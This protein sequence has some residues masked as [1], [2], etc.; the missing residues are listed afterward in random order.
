MPSYKYQFIVILLLSTLLACQPPAT[1]VSPTVIEHNTNIDYKYR[2][3]IVND[4]SELRIYVYRG[5]ALA[6]LGHNHVI[7]SNTFSGQIYQHENLSASRFY[8]SIPVNALVIDDPTLRQ[9]AGEQFQSEPSDK[10]IAGTRK[11]ML[12]S[13]V[14]NAEQY[15]NIR[16]ALLSMNTVASENNIFTVNADLQ[17]QLAGHS[18]TLTAPGKILFRD[19]KIIIESQFQ[20]SQQALGLTPFSVLLGALSVQDHLDIQLH[21]IAQRD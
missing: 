4:L 2:Y 10:D 20:L 12:G 16:I 14:L 19:N 18:N 17:I 9:N 21:L 11:N 5:G 6:K 7:S 15:P 1:N 3:S 8:L 13:K